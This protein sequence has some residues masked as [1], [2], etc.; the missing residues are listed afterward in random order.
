MT[1]HITLVAGPA[2]KVAAADLSVPVGGSKL[3]TRTDW[4]NSDLKAVAAQVAALCHELD[5]EPTI[6]VGGSAGGYPSLK[7][8]S[9]ITDY[10]TAIPNFPWDVFA[11]LVAKAYDAYPKSVAPSEPEP[12]E[13]VEDVAEA[14]IKGDDA[15]LTEVIAVAASDD[16]EDAEKAKAVLAQVPV[17]ELEAWNTAHEKDTKSGTS[18]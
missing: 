10:P 8:N 15:A 4:L 12:A 6:R 9:G 13:L 16:E 3:S 2:H 1:N 7:A 18:A 14:A 17:S 11:P 5:I